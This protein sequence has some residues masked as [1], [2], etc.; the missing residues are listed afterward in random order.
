[1]SLTLEQHHQRF[2]AICGAIA[3]GLNGPGEY[4]WWSEE[5]QD[6]IL[7]AGEAVRVLV[8]DLRGELPTR[9]QLVET[10]ALALDNTRPDE[11]DDF[12]GYR[13]E[14]NNV[15]ERILNALQEL[16]P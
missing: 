4:A 5:Y 16:K 1:M 3:L 12:D 10:V 11:I 8:E 2:N 14:L 7:E 6:E 9:D 15:A 13:D